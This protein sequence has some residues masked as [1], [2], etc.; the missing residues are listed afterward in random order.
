MKIF[1]FSQNNIIHYFNR[2]I[3]TILFTLRKKDFLEISLVKYMLKC[4]VIFSMSVEIIAE[5]RIR[6]L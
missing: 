2:Y 5:K 1:I 6:L 3:T 4:N